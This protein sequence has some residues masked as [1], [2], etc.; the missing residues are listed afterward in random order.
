V[1]TPSRSHLAR[2]PLSSF[3]VLPLLAAAG[4]TAL[5]GGCTGPAGKD[6]PAEL[7]RVTAAVTAPGPNA[8]FPNV[9]FSPAE[10][11]QPLPG[12]IHSATAAGERRGHSNA[13]VVNGHLLV[14]FAQDSGLDGGGLSFYDISDP[15]NPRLVKSVDAP[16]LREAHG[17][18]FSTSYG[19]DHAVFQTIDG[20]QF[21]DL[22]DVTN[23]QMV[24]HLTLPGIEESD[25]AAG[26]WWAFWQAPYV[27]LGGS[28][29]GLYVI[30]ASDL[31]TAH[32]VTVIPTSRTGGFRLGP[33]FAFGNLL[34]TSNADLP[35][36]SVFDISDPRQP[37]LTATLPS[38]PAIYSMQLNGN[39]IYGAGT[40]GRVYVHDVSDPRQ[41]RPVG[42]SPRGPDKGGYLSFQDGFIHGGFSLGYAKF[43]MRTLPYQLVGTGTSGIPGRDEDFGAV[44]GNLVF[45]GND[46]SEGTALIPHQAEPDLTPPAVNAVNP[47]HEAVSQKASTRVGIS[48]TDQIDLDSVIPG[49][50]VVRPVGGA[51]L[52]GKLSTQTNLANFSPDQPLAPDTTYE[53]LVPAGGIRDYAG[54]P[55]ATELRSRFSTGPFVEGGGLK[56]LIPPATPV[57]VRA[58]VSLAVQLS[59]ADPGRVRVTFD[60]GDG[61]VRKARTGALGL[62]HRYREAGHYTVLATVTRGD[63]TTSCSR[64]QTV[65]H[66]L[67]ARAPTSSS[68]IVHDPRSG[69]VWVVN[70]DNDSV[71]AID[72]ATFVRRFEVPVGRN[73]RTLAAAPDGT[74][75]V[76][77]QS[78]GTISVVDGSA[79]RLAATLPVGAGTMPYGVA[80]APDGQAAYVSLQAT[81]QLLKLDP[82]S[83]SITDRFALHG[84]VRGIAVDA[85]SRRVLVTRFISSEESG[86]QVFEVQPGNSGYHRIRS[87]DLHLDPGPDSE[88]SGRGLPNYLTAVTISPDGRRAFVPSKKDNIQ[89]G[90]VRDGQPLTFES[91]VRTVVSQI[92]LRGAYE[93]LSARRDLNDKDMAQSVSF[94][95]YGDYALV[96]LQGSNEVQFLDAYTGALKGGVPVGL[97]PQG[98]AFS[99]DHRTLFV[100]NFLSRS[101]GVY[102]VSGLVDS[103]DTS[104]RPLAVVSTVDRERLPAF[105]LE[106]KRIFFNST[107]R[108]MSRDGYMACASCHLDGDSDGRVWDFTQDGEGLRNTVSL[109]GKSGR[110][111]GPVHWTGN[112]DEIQDF[113]HLIRNFLGGTGFLPDAVFNSGTR[114]QPLGD[115]KTLVSREL[116]ALAAFVSSLAE[117]PQSPHR[118]ADGGLTPAGQSGKQLFAELGCNGCHGG[119]DFTDSKLGLFHDVGTLGP[120][121][122]QRLGLPLTGIDTPSLKGLWLTPPYLHDGSAATLTDVLVARNGAGKHGLTAGLPDWQLAQLTSY[123][124]QLDDRERPGPRI[125][126]L[127]VADTA[128]A[129]D[130]SVRTGFT[131]GDDAY[132]DRMGFGAFFLLDVPATLL[133]TTWIRPANDSVAFS[134]PVLVSFTLDREAAVH[135]LVDQRARP[136]VPWLDASWQPAGVVLLL[137]NGIR[138]L[139]V[140]RKTFPAGPVNLPPLGLTEAVNNYLVVV[141]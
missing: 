9:A 91:M 116:E 16:A 138:P 136:A 73:P 140:L 66:P 21:W 86:A 40:D 127:V 109:L 104:A 62:E 38:G 120:G 80:F 75:W 84:Q 30:D 87:H 11:L 67:T 59:V 117:T 23:P 64:V 96:S 24:K 58:P 98:V 100:N 112:F 48:F 41:I 7:T 132:G 99:A 110:R 28:G 103:S 42:V 97:A 32:L 111:Q 121:S 61:A 125:G 113:E 128:N 141:K 107:D 131:D 43:D 114:N 55:I 65:F 33:V 6:P 25:Y 13:A 72:A 74:I 118:T 122:G 88:A 18:G 139:L 101:V 15:R 52:A 10:V 108:R 53:V 76:T 89:R 85:D 133:G 71:T 45:V 70:P 56:C 8:V 130:W 94:S 17:F 5:T 115:R 39:L 14:P 4:I 92:V 102:D 20:V 36:Y 60:L 93:D 1:P 135:L 51:A 54:N 44:I 106:G 78:D 27:Y 63:E 137:E 29:N 129:A 37:V 31:A 77:N 119:P 124:M 3:P 69:L 134:G 22:T 79:G 81:G 90:P 35:G 26:A 47:A 82:T 50:I 95:K 2:P 12:V 49:S 68:P 105:V 46:H 57:E 19:G 34:V 126:D 123:L 83:R